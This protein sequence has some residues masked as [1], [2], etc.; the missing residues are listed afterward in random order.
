MRA[1]EFVTEAVKQRLDPKCWPRKHKAGTKIKGGIRVNN[2]VPNEGVAEGTE[3][4][5][6]SMV[7]QDQDERNE[8]AN[9]VKS[10][11]GGDWTKGAKMYAQLKKRSSNNIFGDAARLN[12]FMTMKFDFD[13]FTAQDWKNYWLLAQHCDMDRAFQKNALSVI[14]KYQGEDHINYQYLYDRISCGTTGKQKYGTQD[15]CGKD[16]QGVAEGLDDNRVSFKVQKGKNK[17]ATTLSVG[18]NP[19]GVYQYDADTGRSVAEVYPEFKGKGL[20]K[21]LVLHAIYTAAKLGL[22]FQEDESRTSEYDNVLDSLSSNGYIVD[23]DGYWYVTGE[24]EQYLQHSLKQGVAEGLEHDYLSQV[25]NLTWKPVSRSVWNTIQDEGLDEEQDAP[26]HTDWIMASLTIS[27]K[28]ARALQSFD[29]DAIEDFNRFDIHLK[30]RH[31]GLTDLIDYDNGTV[32]IV[33]PSQMQGV[34]EG[35]ENLN[36][37]GNCTQ[38]DVIEHIFGDATGFAQAVDEYGDEFTLDDLVVKYDPETD[39]HSFYYKKQGVA[40]AVAP[41]QQLQSSVIYHGSIQW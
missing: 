17:F 32:T 26:K 29:S 41:D 13:K 36:Y 28:D 4:S 6:S 33:K 3:Q 31:P 12:Q 10:Q 27:P 11:A 15:I 8:Y 37:I 39:V 25:P 7:S 20:G 34:V 5:L 18:V 30:S 9:F 22:D 2:C 38:D 40:E 16:K 19:V 35:A 24:G 21:L 23:D 14:K 1:K